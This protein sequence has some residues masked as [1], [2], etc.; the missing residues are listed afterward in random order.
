MHDFYQSKNLIFFFIGF[1]CWCHVKRPNFGRKP[2]KR[3][4][5][6]SSLWF[7]RRVFQ[8]FSVTWRHI[9][10][11]CPSGDH[12]EIFHHHFWIRGLGC[13]HWSNDGLND[14]I[15][16]CER[17]S[18][19]GNFFVF[20]DELQFLSFG[21][22]LFNVRNRICFILW[23]ISSEYFLVEYSVPDLNQNCWK[24]KKKWLTYEGIIWRISLIA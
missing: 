21:R 16:T 11:K 19:I 18:T 3:C 7:H 2:F 23:H 22:N 5:S 14:Q 13:L 9:R 10:T 8:N 12:F 4:C 20:S 6:N 15:Y 17:F 24:L 1:A